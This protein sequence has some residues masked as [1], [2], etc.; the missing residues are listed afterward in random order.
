MPSSR[1]QLLLLSSAALLSSRVCARYPSPES[2]RGI[3]AGGKTVVAFGSCN[4]HDSPQDFWPL[5]AHERPDLFVWLG[6][7]VYADTPV[8]LKWRLPASAAAVGAM[9]RAQAAAPAYAAFAA[10]HAVVGVYDDHDTGEN[11]SDRELFDSVPDDAIQHHL[12]DFFDEPRAWPTAA[13]A[14]ERGRGPPRAGVP[15]PT[16]PPV[17]LPP[18]ATRL[19]ARARP[20]AC[21]RR[22][23]SASRR[24]ASC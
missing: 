1:S 18:Q 21:T 10:A 13:A 15:A 12:L 17:V 24:T 5:I 6:D 20:A 7:I 8:F 23:C 14:R 22:T 3:G 11:D 2:L 19:G 16:A 9:L 4:K